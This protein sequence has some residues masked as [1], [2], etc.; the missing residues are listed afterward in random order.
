MRIVASQVLLLVI[1]LQSCASNFTESQ[2]LGDYEAVFDFGVQRLVLKVNKSYE[3]TFTYNDG[4]VTKNEGIW[5]YPVKTGSETCI[6]LVDALK[7]DDN[8]GRPA[9][10]SLIFPVKM[11]FS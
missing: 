7:F 4:K 6:K 10:S 8:H 11:L 5:I 3:Q 2:L 1:F 9:G